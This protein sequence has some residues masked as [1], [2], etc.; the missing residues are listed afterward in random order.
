MVLSK[1]SGKQRQVLCWA[2][3]PSTRGRYDAILADGA[4]RSGKTVS[5]IIGFIHWAMRYFDGQNFAICGHTVQSAERNI[6][7]PLG[8]MEDLTDYYDMKY[9][10]SDHRLDVRKGAKLNRFYLFGGKDASSYTLIQGM[11]LAG[12]LLDEVALMPRSFVEQ[13]LARC[14]VE[15]SKF[16]FNCN[17]EHPDHW[18]YTEW[19]KDAEGDNTRHTL[20]VHFTMDDNPA[21]TPEMRERYERLYPSGVFRERYI[22]GRWVRAEGLIYP[23]FGEDN[24]VQKPPAGGKW[25]ISIDYGTLN[26]TSMGL[27]CVG[28]EQAVRV[29]EYYYD[30]RKEGNQKTDEEYYEALVALAQKLPIEA[31][32]VD[33]SAASFITCIRRHGRFRVM[34]ADN[35]VL[36]GIRYTASLLAQG[37]VAITPRCENIRR[38]FGAYVWDQKATDDRPRKEHDHAMDE[39]RYLCYTV[40]RRMPEYQPKGASAPSAAMHDRTLDIREEMTGQWY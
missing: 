8:E 12:V 7:M 28:R 6:I 9:R 18:L 35:S 39:M 2:H 3:K 33:P 23:M 34:T 10:R 25:Y 22:L 36:D 32:I 27:W 40:L 31:V 38:E 24:V 5:M 20:R 19:V 4:V 30:G 11:T 15:G 14:S 37:K 17:P 1:I 16:W 26:P 13:A 29:K 21:L